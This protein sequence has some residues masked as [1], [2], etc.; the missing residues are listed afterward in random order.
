MAITIQLNDAPKAWELDSPEDMWEALNELIN[1]GYKGQV[2]ACR[3]LIAGNPTGPVTWRITVGLDET[4]SLES[5][6]GEM[7][8]RLLL[9]GGVL[10]ALSAEELEEMTA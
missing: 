2:D 6:R 10:R 7:G 8:Q 1:L 9:M 3:D 5:I 4:A